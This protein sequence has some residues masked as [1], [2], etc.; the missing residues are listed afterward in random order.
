M[1]SA[2]LEATAFR[3]QFGL[4]ADRQW[5]EAVFAN[6]LASGSEFGVPLLPAEIEELNRRALEEAAVISVVRRY[7]AGN[8]DSWAGLYVDQA[9]GGV[10]VALFTADTDKHLDA[11]R[12]TVHPNARIVVREAQFTEAE[13]EEIHERLSRN[14][15]WFRRVDVTLLGISM[16]VPGNRVAVLVA[17]ADPHAVDALLRKQFATDDRV[18]V[19]DGGESLELL[20]RGSLEG[21][22]I[23]ANGNPLVG[24]DIQAIGDVGAAEPDGGV[25]YSTRP[26]GTFQIPSLAA[27]G[28]E[29]RAVDLMR[30]ETG[31]VIGSARV[32]VRPRETAFVQIVAAP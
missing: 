22:V 1:L 2:I 25:G 24:L 6:P 11:L 12:R 7:A 29:V 26:D 8:G 13:L 21:R 16:D 5:V 3:E 27:M 28:W 30:G 31:L 10:V 4:R 15:E 17:D 20:P 18:E 9:G 23:D 32:V 19:T 14:V